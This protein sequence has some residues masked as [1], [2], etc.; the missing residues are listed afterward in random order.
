MNERRRKRRGIED[1]TKRGRGERDEENKE[2]EADQRNGHRLSV[3][4]NIQFYD[5][6]INVRE[7]K[8]ITSDLNNK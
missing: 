8:P 5:I 2:E 1:D 3:P 4:H 7:F 6:F